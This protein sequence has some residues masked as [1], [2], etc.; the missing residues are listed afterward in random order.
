MNIA[1]RKA[2]PQDASSILEIYKPYVEDTAITFE[3]DVPDIDEFTSRIVNTLKK[4]PYLVAEID[5]V[6]KGYAYASSFHPRAAYQWCV[7]TSIYIEKNSHKCGIGKALLLALEK[8]LTQMG[9]LNANACI[10]KAEVE[11]E[12][13]TNASIRFHTKMGYSMVG[14]FHKCGYKFDRWY[15]MVWME[16]FL[17]EHKQPMN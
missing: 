5:G 8:E 4:Y 1:I 12:Y 15:N 10:A 16:K 7:E 17:G 14:E 11:D 13:L 9:I 3:Y 2:T 6:I